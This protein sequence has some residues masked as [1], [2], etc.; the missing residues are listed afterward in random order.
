MVDLTD[1]VLLELMDEALAAHMVEDVP[2]GRERYRF[3]HALV[4]ETLAEEL[5]TSRRVRLHARIG[6]ALEDLYRADAE[7]HAAEL[8]HHFAEAETL[9][10]TEKLVHYSLLAG[11]HALDF[12]AF[13]DAITHFERGLVAR[14]ITLTGAEVASDKESADL[15]FGLAR[16]KSATF[17]IDL[18][19]QE[20]FDTLSRAFEY[21]AQTGNTAL[22]VAAAEFPINPTGRI[23]GTAALMA[24]ALTLVPADSHDA[25]RILSRYGGVLG[26]A[27]SDY[28]GAQQALG[29]ALSIARCEEDVPLE[30]QALT[31]AADVSEQHLH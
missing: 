17:G 25:G 1:T 8:A 19:R 13:E 28:E 9:L 30:V 5:S 27:Q 7:G 29:R 12:H 2:E 23:P 22:A 21:Y 16:A 26:L 14:G 20:A 6:E 18:I 3:S 24:R 15:L 10:G 11:E 31:Y 4:Q